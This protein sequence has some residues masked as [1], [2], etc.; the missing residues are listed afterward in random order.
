MQPA[1]P[2]PKIQVRDVVAER[3]GRVVLRVP[4]LEIPAGCVTAL[5]GPNGAG[6]STLLRVLQL[7]DRPREGALL[8]DGVSMTEDPLATRRRMA[9]A[10]QEPLLLSTS[11]GKNVEI[12]LG[13]HHVSRRERRARAARWL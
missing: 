4:R 8:L 6:K 12:A 5:I 9:A 13:L 11:V 1:A 10:F 3:G 7:L 2:P